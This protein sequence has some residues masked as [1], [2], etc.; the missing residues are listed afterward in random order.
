V[1]LEASDAVSGFQ[2]SAFTAGHWTAGPAPPSITSGGI[3]PVFSTANTIQP[4][5]W[6]SLYGSNLASQTSL[7]KGDFP[8]NLGGVSVTID[9]KPAYLWFVARSD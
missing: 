9:N 4:G 3:V 2:T 7:W 6:V 8:T 5:S 1:Q